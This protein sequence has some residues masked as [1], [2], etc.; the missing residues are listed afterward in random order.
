NANVD[1]KKAITGANI[2]TYNLTEKDLEKYIIFEVTP[3]AKTGTTKGSPMSY[4]TKTVVEEVQ[5]NSY[6]KLGLIRNKSYV[7]KVA[8]ILKRYDGVANVVVKQESN[9]YRVYADFIDKVTA[10]TVLNGMKK[11]EYIVN[12]YFYKK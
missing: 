7:E 9:Y 2:I 3:V 10:K 12:Y 6:V 5:Y 4:I 8:K 1:N 11:N